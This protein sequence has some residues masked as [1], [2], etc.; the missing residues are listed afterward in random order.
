MSK[1][2]K[3]QTR[4]L[5]HSNIKIKIP[6]KYEESL[7]DELFSVLEDVNKTYNSYSE[8]SFIDKI[9]KNAGKFVKVNDETIEMLEKILYF[10]D[11]L[12][13]EYDIT[14][15]PL[16]K[17]WGFYK[18]N[19][20]SIPDKEKIEEIKKIVNYKEM[21]INKINN[22]VKIGAGQ[23]I[24]TGSF[25]KSYAI[26]RLSEKMKEKGITDAVINAGGSS[27]LT[28]NDNENR[29]LGII[30][31]NPTPHK[32][33]EKDQKGYPIKITDSDYEGNDEYNDLFD[34]EISNEAYST[35]NQMN[36]YIEINGE[37]YGHIISP[38]TGYPGK[39]KQ[40]G[41]ITEKA[42]DGDIIST[43]LFNQSPENFYKIMKQLSEKMKIEGYLVDNEG[44]IHYSEDFLNYV[45]F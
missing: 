19:M 36:T 43:G 45:D 14:I 16:I 26:D 21:Y 23:E 7:F 35:S 5:F 32:K 15:M 30:V 20:I 27:I 40:I 31:E 17:L 34:I 44:K 8:N 42:F 41:I 37:K 24:I 1:L 39:N 12:E 11:M 4:F 18:K 38:K 13:G 9:N 10:S 28:I 29:N 22:E 33:I 3:V 2:Y 6:D 25:I